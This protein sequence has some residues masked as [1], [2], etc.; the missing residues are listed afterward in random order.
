MDVLTLLWEV[1]V[2]N[3]HKALEHVC[4]HTHKH[5]HKYPVLSDEQG[6][7]SD[8]TVSTWFAG[9]FSSESLICA[10]VIHQIMRLVEE[11]CAVTFLSDQTYDFI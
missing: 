6:S 5:I 1:V 7:D 3:T 4:K 9:T 8:W 11:R 10:T 2:I